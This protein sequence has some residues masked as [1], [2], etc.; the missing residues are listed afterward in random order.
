MKKKKSWYAVRKGRKTGLFTD[1]EDCKVQITGYAGAEYKG[2]YTKEE[3]ERYLDLPD[4]A[5]N[6][7]P[8][9]NISD[10][11]IVYIDGSYMPHLPDSFSFGAV[12]IYKGEIKTYAEKITD[13]E[14]A[15]MRNVA[16]EVHGAVYAMEK[17]LELGM[18]EIDLYYDYAGIEKW[19]TGEWKANKKGTK[20]LQDYYH[21]IKDKLIV[22]F[23]KVISHSGDF[24]NEMAD[25]LA[26]SE[27][28]K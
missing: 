28:M 18:K 13:E 23:H 3:A 14:E 22:H 5:E 16:G 25:K 24:Y 10:R 20:A 8:D 27:L 15:A 9:M 17:C 26:K 2:F 12:F 6:N 7:K 19:C 1:W 4:V 11:M 21:S